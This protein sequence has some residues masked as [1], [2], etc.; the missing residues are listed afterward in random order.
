M[1]GCREIRHRRRHPTINGGDK[2]NLCPS[3]P[4]SRDHTAS[5]TMKHSSMLSVPRHYQQRQHTSHP[6]HFPLV[7]CFFLSFFRRFS[8]PLR[9]ISLL[10]TLIRATQLTTRTA[11]HSAVTQRPHPAR[12]PHP[13]RREIKEKS[14]G[15][16][17]IAS[18]HPPSAK[19]SFHCTTPKGWC[20]LAAGDSF[21][22][23]RTITRIL[24][25][26]PDARI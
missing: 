6:Q 7:C 22:L 24:I 12:V 16:M 10:Q 15:R 2:C 8:A 3:S 5:G 13:I 11:D 21:A 14:A 4:L 19:F 17:I 25:G 20:H 23:H 26:G 1:A 9:S 18:I